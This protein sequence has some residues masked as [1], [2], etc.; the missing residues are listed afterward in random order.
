MTATLPMKETTGTTTQVPQP[1]RRWMHVVSHTDPSYGGLSSAVPSLAASLSSVACLDVSLAAFCAP[2]EEHRP[3]EMGADDIH[4]WPTSRSRWIRDGR[5]QT[6]FAEA[7]R[8]ADGLHVH[9]IWEQ[10]TAMSCKLARRLKKPYVL[11]AHGMLEPWALATKKLKKRV[12]AAL[13]ERANVANASCL[14]ALTSAEAEQYRDFGASCPIAVIPNAVTLPDGV[15]RDLFFT[16]FPVLRGKRILL[17]LSRL[18]PKKGL[19]LLVEAWARSGRQHA[20]AHLV[21]AGPDGNG[22]QAKLAA[23]AAAAGMADRVTFTGML[24]GSM[25]WSA[26]EAAEG[27]VL[28]S[29]S[30][31]LSMALLEAMGM[32]LPV[33]ATRA[34]NMPEITSADAGWEVGADVEALASAVSDFLN[35]SIEENEI[36]GRNGS[37]LIAA[38]YAPPQVARQM[39]EVYEFV[40][41][42]RRPENVT[43]PMGGAR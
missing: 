42:G 32:G 37:T 34:C 3:A 30:E 41:G 24:T 27:Y 17:F 23:Q 20:D 8:E 29:Y 35:R 25:K 2:G 22:I 36:K 7:V 39:A 28:P 5:L 14:H 19:D 18:H 6:V 9:G 1:A 33:I 13:I 4:F 16:R 21:I 26:L 12:Y 15:D 11:S 10:S 38:R 40:L 43:L 31:G